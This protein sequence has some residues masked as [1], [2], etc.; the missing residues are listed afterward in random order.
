MSVYKIDLTWKTK[1]INFYFFIFTI[2][3]PAKAGA[4]RLLPPALKHHVPQPCNTLHYWR[5]GREIPM[6]I[7]KPMNV[8]IKN[9]S[10]VDHIQ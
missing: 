1:Q 3:G 5:E 10:L 7:I 2:N 6:I 4:T 9:F 8:P